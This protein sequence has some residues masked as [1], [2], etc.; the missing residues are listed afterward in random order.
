MA[1]NGIAFEGSRELLSQAIVESL[2]SWPEI[3]RRVFVETHYRNR[4]VE[5]I[6]RDLGIGCREVTQILENCEHRLFHALKV[7]RDVTSDEA[8]AEPPH[9][10]I[11]AS[12]AC[13]H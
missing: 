1:T 12:R 10:V 7:F 11:Y 2:N 3:H 13:C 9:P 4:S 8:P 5:E 6:S